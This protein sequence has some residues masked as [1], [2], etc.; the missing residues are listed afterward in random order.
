MLE[1]NGSSLCHKNRNRAVCTA[2]NRFC[3]FRFF[4]LVW[5]LSMDRHLPEF[6]YCGL[7]HL[8]IPKFDCREF[9][10]SLLMKIQ[11]GKVQVQ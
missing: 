11:H 5:L 4:I 3:N 9:Q 10:T 6:L 2:V 1:P 8:D 7:F